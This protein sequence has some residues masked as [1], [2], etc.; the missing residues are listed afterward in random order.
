MTARD[1]A[2]SDATESGRHR[3]S[4]QAPQ[5]PRR[6]PS[7]TQTSLPPAVHCDQWRRGR[8]RRELPAATSWSA[9]PPVPGRLAS[10]C[11]PS[12]RLRH[13]AL[14]RG[15]GHVHDRR[16]RGRCRRGPRAGR[17][18]ERGSLRRQRPARWCRARGRHQRR[19][20]RHDGLGARRGRDEQHDAAGRRDA[21]RGGRAR[22]DAARHRRRRRHPRQR[23][24]PAAPEPRR[25]RRR[26]RHL[27]RCHRSARDRSAS[28][29]RPGRRLGRE[30]GHVA[31]ADDPE[32]PLALATTSG[33]VV[34]FAD[35]RSD[36]RYIKA[37]ASQ[38]AAGGWAPV[39]W[40]SGLARSP[41]WG[42]GLPVA[43]AAAD[44]ALVSWVRNGAT[45]ERG[46]LRGSDT[47]GTKSP[48]AAISNV[49]VRF[50]RGAAPCG[51]ANGVRYCAAGPLDI[52]VLFN[53]TVGDAA[54]SFERAGRRATGAYAS[55]S[56]AGANNIPIRPCYDVLPRQYPVHTRQVEARRPL[57][58]A[59]RARGCIRWLA[60]TVASTASRPAALS[61][62]SSPRPPEHPERADWRSIHCTL[63]ITLAAPDSVNVHRSSSGRRSS[64]RPTR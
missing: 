12:R 44:R 40:L 52:R 43:A 6:P 23:E 56:K 16:R 14:G 9:A 49:R 59:R 1:T 57:A 4:P 27:R 47:R 17:D 10:I 35:L 41:S 61:P 45:I 37:S 19:G 3:P 28:R 11:R 55:T 32:S 7:S 24:R 39:S 5:A 20:R 58:R 15:R 8:L 50:S 62:S 26:S 54:V 22:A 25:R 36:A 53:A 30:G 34:A 21:V 33:D 46:S 29:R 63:A 38:A 31:S 48:L 64:R 51:S 13:R 2:R 60:R 18:V 42:H